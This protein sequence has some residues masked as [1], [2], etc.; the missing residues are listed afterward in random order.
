MAVGAI[1]NG[2]DMTRVPKM[3][4][5]CFLAYKKYSNFYD[6]LQDNLH[7]AVVALDLVLASTSILLS[8]PSS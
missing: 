8:P 4:R 7:K 1:Y 5:M 6:L 3:C 2:S